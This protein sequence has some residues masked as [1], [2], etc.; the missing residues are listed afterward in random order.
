MSGVVAVAKKTL[1][2]EMRLLETEFML[3]VEVL[4]VCGDKNLSIV[5]DSKFGGRLKVT[6]PHK[7][8]EEPARYTRIETAEALKAELIKT[9]LY[10]GVSGGGFMRF[11]KLPAGAMVDWATGQVTTA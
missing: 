7:I 8:A 5:L 10:V 11:R 2:E 4:S 9:G 6:F 3:P 1:A